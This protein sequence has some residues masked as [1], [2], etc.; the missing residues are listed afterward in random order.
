MCP[1]RCASQR[2]VAF[3]NES[4]VRT[5]NARVYAQCLDNADVSA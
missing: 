3:I 5:N 2:S 1:Y 4:R